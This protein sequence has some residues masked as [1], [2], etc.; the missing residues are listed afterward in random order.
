M[1][2]HMPFDPERVWAVIAD[3]ESTPEWVPDLVSARRLDSGAIGVGSKLEE[4]MQ[5]QGRKVTATVEIVGY[6]E[7]ELLEHK[8]EGGPVKFGGKFELNPSGNGCDVT[9]SWWLEL[10]GMFRLASPMAASWARKNI[11]ESMKALER[12]LAEG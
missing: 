6:R 3:L 8:G 1:T 7:G 9:N 12:K 11:E 10:S 4:V 5:V 2:T